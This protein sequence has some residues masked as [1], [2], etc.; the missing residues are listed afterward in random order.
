M[1]RPRVLVTQPLL[2][3]APA[4]LAEACEVVAYPDGGDQ[5]DAALAAA[6]EGC[7]GIVSQSTDTIGERVLSRPRLR[8]VANAAV[9]YNNV[10]VDAATR[11]RVVVTN[12]PGVLD[13]T[14]ADLAFALLMAAARRVGEGDRF[15][16]GGRW[17]RWTIGQMLGHDVHGATLGIVGLGRI[18]RVVAK[19]ASGFDMRVLYCARTRLPEA[20]ERTLGVEWRSLGGLLRESDLVSLHVPLTSETHHLIGAAELRLMK[21]TAVLVNVSRGPVVDVPALA[22]ALRERRIF[23][24]GLDVFEDEPNVPAELLPLENVV[25]T[26]HIGSGSVRTRSRMCELAARNAVAVLSG[27][28]P[29]TAVNGEVVG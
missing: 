6:A 22:E 18:G 8:V 20:E 1:T 2:D 14:T 21:P 10:D 9:G 24:A 23:A 13:D 3:P 4:V 5:S 11:H 26:P 28:P 29:L 12:T 16:R 15:V 7:D 19:R 17:R 25:L 27:A